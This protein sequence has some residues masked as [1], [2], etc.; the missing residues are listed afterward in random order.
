MFNEPVAFATGFYYLEERI[1][2]NDKAL[3]AQQKENAKL[4]SLYEMAISER[5]SA[6]AKLNENQI[7]T[8][9][10]VDQC[11]Q[12][13]DEL[14]IT[15]SDLKKQRDDYVALREELAIALKK[16]KKQLTGR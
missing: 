2:N 9:E 10:I 3:L 4:R 12:Y 7:K 14:H 11:K 13:S 1:L 5:D 8:Q 16:I 15:L 6:I